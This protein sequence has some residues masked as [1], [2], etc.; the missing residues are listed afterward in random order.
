MSAAIFSEKTAVSICGVGKVSKKRERGSVGRE[1]R[2]FVH[3]IKACPPSSEEGG[4]IKMRA[5]FLADFQPVSAVDGRRF[6]RF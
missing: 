4:E 5:E 6:G 1:E 2:I 3:G